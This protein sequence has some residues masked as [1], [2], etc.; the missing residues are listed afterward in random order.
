VASEEVVC[1][2]DAA[3]RPPGTTRV[4]RRAEMT[5]VAEKYGLRLGPRRWPAAAPV[6]ASELINC[7]PPGPRVFRVRR[8]AVQNAP[9]SEWATARPMTA[10]RPSAAT[11]VATTTG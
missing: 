4:G 10:R 9:S 8:N 11:P 1:P 2:G 6:W 5:P 7:A 3:V